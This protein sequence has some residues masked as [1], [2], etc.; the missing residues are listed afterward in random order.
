MKCFFI[1]LAF[2]VSTLA[3]GEQLTYKSDPNAPIHKTGLKIS[4]DWFKHVKFVKQPTKEIINLPAVWDWRTNP[5]GLTA[6]ADQGNC[7]SCWAFSIAATF[8]DTLKIAGL[9][10]RHRSNIDL[11]E[12]YLLS[13]NTK[14][15]N[16]E[17]GGFFDAQDMYVSPGA[18]IESAYPYTAQTGKCKNNLKYPYMEKSWAYVGTSNPDN[19]DYVVPTDEE[20]KTA[21]YVHG[22]VSIAIN[23]TTAMMFYMGGVFN[24]CVPTKPEELNHAINIIGWNDEKGAWIVRNSWGKSWGEQGF[25]YIK[26]GCNLIGYAANYAEYSNPVIK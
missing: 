21:V 2:L 5:N 24:S 20:I 9:K 6:I 22:P 7:G 11:S 15:Y 23:A 26:Y 19:T 16:C 1:T 12:Q 25:G 3:A 13:C 4:K 17:E 18:V 14:G 10:G 8:G